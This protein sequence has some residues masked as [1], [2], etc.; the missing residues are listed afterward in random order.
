[1]NNTELRKKSFLKDFPAC[2]NWHTGLWGWRRVN[3][4]YDLSQCRFKSK[5]AASRDRNKSNEMGYFIS[6][7]ELVISR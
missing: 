5:A 2:Q 4:C 3:G 7:G 1:M 6:S